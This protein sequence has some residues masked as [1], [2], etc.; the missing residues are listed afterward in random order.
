MYA[1][2]LICAKGAHMLSL[3]GLG[4]LLWGL[5]TGLGGTP[6]FFCAAGLVMIYLDDEARRSRLW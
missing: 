5:W 4:L 2:R 1:C 6:F 3:L